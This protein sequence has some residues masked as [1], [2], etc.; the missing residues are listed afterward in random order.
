MSNSSFGETKDCK[1]SAAVMGEDIVRELVSAAITAPSGGNVQAWRFV[2]RKGTELLCY[3]DPIR[4]KNFLD[5]DFLATHVAL[6]AAVENIVIA[7]AA[8]GLRCEVNLFPTSDRELVAVLHFQVSTTVAHDAQ[9]ASQIFRRATNR[10]LGQRLALKA[11]ARERLCSAANP[12]AGLSFILSPR[13]LSTVGQVAGA[14]DRFRLCSELL[15]SELLSE[16]RWTQQ[17]AERTRD[18]VDVRTLELNRAQRAGLRA[19]ASFRFVRML[20]RFGVQKPFEEMSQSAVQHASALGLLTVAG[21]D[22]RAYF[23]G[24]RALQRVWLTATELG[25]AIQPLAVAPYLFARLERGSGFSETERT[26]LT[27]LRQRFA[28]AAPVDA[29]R[30]EIMLFRITTADPPSTRSLRRALENV[31][32]FEP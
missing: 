8:K 19:L 27:A 30:G 29:E 15:H 32:F 7:A 11:D 31:L 20:A 24:G 9:L 4:A 13:A 3:F 18:G 14:C 22:R 25:L 6:G 10:R 1:S 21:V 26:I 16:L 17:E 23:M 28:E 5:F 2:L 12:Y